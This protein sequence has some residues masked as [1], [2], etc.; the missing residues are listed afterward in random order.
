[1]AC[2]QLIAFVPMKM[3]IILIFSSVKTGF[4]VQ[5]AAV[6]RPFCTGTDCITVNQHRVDFQSAEEACHDSKGELLTLQSE[7]DENTVKILSQKLFGDFWI[8][9][10]LPAATCSNLSAPLRGYKWT[11]TGVYSFNPA[12]STWKESVKLCS[13]SCVSFSKNQKWTE[14]LCSDKTDGYLCKTKHKDA[15]RAQ[16]LSEPNV[17]QSS[18]GC[19]GEPCEHTCTAVKGGYICSCFKGYIPDSKSPE[20]CKIHCAQEKCPAVCVRHTDCSCPDGYLLNYTSCIDIDECSSEQCDHGCRNTFGSFVCSCREGFVLKNQVKCVKAKSSKSLV[21]TTPVVVSVN[22][23]A[24]NNHTLSGS[25]APL[26]IWILV[27]VAVVV[28]IVVMRFYVVQRQK[29][30]ELNSG[31]RSAAPMDNIEC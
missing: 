11:S 4:G 27:V 20:R 29:H 6:C 5:Q 1:M 26:W 18:K 16:A 8:G 7:E 3:M 22:Q 10:R 24:A 15:C 9:L 28:F 19:S 13:P 31:Q 14:R 21:V 17:I 30:R 12:S 25:T 23:A 2:S